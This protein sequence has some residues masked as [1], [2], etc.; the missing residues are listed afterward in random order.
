MQPLRG[1]S[2]VVERIFDICIYFSHHVISNRGCV[3]DTV[4]SLRRPLRRA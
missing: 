3:L 1:C 2:N 4:A